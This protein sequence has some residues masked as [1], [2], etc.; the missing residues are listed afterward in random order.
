MISVSVGVFGLFILNVIFYTVEKSTIFLFLLYIL[1][2]FLPDFCLLSLN[3][4]RAGLG[5]CSSYDG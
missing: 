1:C 3:F 2:S 4:S 5:E